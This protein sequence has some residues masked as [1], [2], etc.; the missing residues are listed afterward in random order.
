MSRTT[1]PRC[2]LR[3]LDC[4]S[5]SRW[6]C[7]SIFSSH[8]SPR[9]EVTSLPAP[10]LAHP[11]IDLLLSKAPAFIRTHLQPF[12]WKHLRMKLDVKILRYLSKEDFRV[13]TAIEMGMRNHEIVPVELVSIR[14]WK[15]NP[16][17]LPFHPAVSCPVPTTAPTPERKSKSRCKPS[18]LA[19]CSICWNSHS[20]C[21][22]PYGIDIQPSNQLNLLILF[23][24][25]SRASSAAV[26]NFRSN[27]I[28]CNTNRLSP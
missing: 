19:S 10:E 6:P 23:F 26:I 1:L 12:T 17:L 9:C 25:N 28:L 21:H 22:I 7:P 13:L 24:L 14:L 8:L 11:S 20:P 16:F 2:V 5:S 15:H 3:K 4:Q 27:N 18:K